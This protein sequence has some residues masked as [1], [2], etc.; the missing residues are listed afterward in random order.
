MVQTDCHIALR[1]SAG[2]WIYRPSIDISLLWSESQSRLPA[3]P[4]PRRAG[5]VTHPLRLS[6][7][8]SLV[9]SFSVF[10]CVVAPLRQIF[11]LFSI[12][13]IRLIRGS[14]RLP[15]STPLE[16]RDLDISPVY[17]HIAPLERKSIPSPRSSVTSPRGLGN[18]PPTP[19]V[20]PFSG[21]LVFCFPLR[22]CALAS[23]IFTVFNPCNPLIRVIRDSDEH[24]TSPGFC[25]SR[26]TSRRKIVDY[27]KSTYKS[28][29]HCVKYSFRSSAGA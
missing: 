21:Y 13:V 15:H 7:S 12:G 8:R 4:L 26:F 6:S 14:D 25:R 29:H 11:L 3:P 2:I 1:W 24:H 23:N 27:G 19:L 9:I 17:R 10:P 5:W 16:C 22:R 20:F 18:P 28:L